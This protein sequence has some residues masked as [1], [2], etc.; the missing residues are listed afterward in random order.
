MD[1]SKFNDKKEWRKFGYGLAVILLIIGTLQLFFGTSDLYWYLYASAA[2][3]AF[4][5]LLLPLLLK[6]LFILFSYFGFV[7]N[8]VVTHIILTFVFFIVITPVGWL[9]RLLGKKLIDD[10]FP[11]RVES[12]WINR[13]Q[14]K[15]D[16][17]SYTRQF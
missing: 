4:A 2:V 5:S 8:W 12:Y 6:P 1:K 10:S 17:E 15:T 7:M 16:K 3:A 9:L 14:N 11:D 13:D